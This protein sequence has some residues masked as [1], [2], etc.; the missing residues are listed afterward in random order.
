M[1]K[2]ILLIAVIL[3]IFGV[4]QA[5]SLGLGLQGNFYV[6]PDYR[7]DLGEDHSPIAPG[8]S[9]LVSPSRKFNIAANYLFPGADDLIKLHGL[10]LTMDFAPSALNFKLAGSAPTLLANPKAWSLNLTVG[11][12]AFL[13]FVFEDNLF[14]FNKDV[15][16]SGG[17]RVPVGVNFLFAQNFELFVHIAPSWGLVFVPEFGAGFPFFPVALGGRI[18][19]GGW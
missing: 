11:V 2:K 9:V 14:N 10:G 18:W 3:C 8:L 6:Q 12:G 7:G 17:V 1:K 19:L 5:H 13:D 16:F 15:D 4:V